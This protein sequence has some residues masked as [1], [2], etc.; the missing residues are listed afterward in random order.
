MSRVRFWRGCWAAQQGLGR[1]L[2]DR[3]AKETGEPASVAVVGD[4]GAEDARRNWGRGRVVAW[5]LRFSRA[6]LSSGEKS[7]IIF[8]AAA[9]A[10]G[11]AIGM[12]LMP[13][14]EIGTGW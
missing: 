4:G 14:V 7:I 13:A 12:D 5:R 1:Q 2:P 9:W 11:C 6:I 10:L 3:M 8:A